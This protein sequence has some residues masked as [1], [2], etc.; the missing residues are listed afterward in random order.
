MVVNRLQNDLL[1][2]GKA[3]RGSKPKCAGQLPYWNQI[4]LFSLVG[5]TLVANKTK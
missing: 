1:N 2:S 3:P 4:S 5:P